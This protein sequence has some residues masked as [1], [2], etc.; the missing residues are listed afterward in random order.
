MPASQHKSPYLPRYWPTWLLLGG[1]WGITRLP[2]AWQLAIGRGI[3]WLAR[4]L[5]RQRRHIA[6]TNLRLCFPDLDSRQRQE[7]LAA[8][9]ASLGIAVIEFALS[10]WGTE[11]KLAT[12]A[13]LHGL[14]HLQAALQEG[15]GVILLDVHF[16]TLEIGGRLLARHMPFHVLYRE[17]KN[18]VIEKVMCKARTHLYEKAIPRSDM[19]SMVSSLKQNKAVWFAPDQDHGVR[20]SVFVPFFGIPAATITTTSRIA[21]ICGAR[22]VPFF[23]QRLANGHGYRLVLLPA[24]ENFPSDD[25]T[26]DTR[27]LMQLI[28]AQVRQYPEQYL[29]AHRRFKTRPPGARALYD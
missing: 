26:E 3:G 5:A 12:L 8:H 18:P 24:V 14:E 11:R 22:V 16:T 2:Y 21:R 17:H 20:N 28:E 23:Q 27:R 29:W 10:W 19:V 6:A 25:S 13:Q 4:H 15:N 9:F 1:L 7:L